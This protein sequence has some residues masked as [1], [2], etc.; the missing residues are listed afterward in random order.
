MNTYYSLYGF[1]L[2][3]ISSDFV[4]FRKLAL[5]RNEKRTN[6][7]NLQQKRSNEEDEL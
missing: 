6:I 2:Y 7:I 1:G 5:G 3:L 4:C